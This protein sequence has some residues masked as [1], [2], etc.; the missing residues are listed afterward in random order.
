VR[1]RWLPLFQPIWLYKDV[2]IDPKAVRLHTAP[3]LF[4]GDLLSQD[5]L[6]QIGLRE[7]FA[8]PLWN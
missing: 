2:A 3:R 6:P 5:Y 7:P 8:Q 1:S 4:G